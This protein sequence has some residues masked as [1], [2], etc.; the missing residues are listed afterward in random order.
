MRLRAAVWPAVVTAPVA[1]ALLVYSQTAAFA[2]DEG[3]HV[4]AAQ[5][6]AAGKRPYVDFVFPQTP[7]NAW[8]TGL[9]MRLFGESWRVAHSI[10]ALATAGAVFLAADYVFRRLADPRA[11]AA[12]ALLTGLNAVLFEYGT[13]GQSY[14]MSLLLM[15]VAF[16]L[17]VAERAPAAVAGLSAGAAAA[18]SLLTAP[19]LPVLAGW[20]W[21]RKGVGSA[22]AYVAGA[23]VPFVPIAWLFFAAPRRTWFNVAGFQLMYRRVQWSDWFTH[24]LDIDTAWANAPQ[25]L[26]LMALA[27]AC[28]VLLRTSGWGAQLRTEIYLCAA[29]GAAE[30]VYLLNVHPGFARYYLLAVPFAGILSGF[31]LGL[32]GRSARG[33]WPVAA[34]GLIM[35]VS[36]V[37]YA[38]ADRD[39]YSWYDFEEIGRRIN[40]VT[41]AGA[42]LYADEHAY[43]MARRIP[44]EGMSFNYSHKV[45]LPPKE[46]AELGIVSR[47]EVDRRIRA[48]AYAT[49]E[50]CDSEEEIARLGVAKI[51]GHRSDIGNCSVFW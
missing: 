26:M 7:L 43:F 22:L 44:P 40:Q 13:V 3:F 15:M 39:D 23:V 20:F 30:T 38:I 27:I 9:A 51:Y 31:G 2:W 25:A 36:L 28:L 35:S 5:L 14:G 29:I 19:L 1:I 34:I 8:I 10:Q 49:F 6:I 17:A 47:S 42:P 37:R 33:W 16:R 11:T 32:M 21:L 18:A 41:P 4:L 24:D 46:A 12:T 48:H 45:E 50:T